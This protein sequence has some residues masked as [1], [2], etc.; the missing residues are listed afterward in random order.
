[1][2]SFHQVSI[3]F[4]GGQVVTARVTEEQL[5]ALLSALAGT[6]GGGWHELSTEDGSLRLDIAQVAYVRT[7][8][9][10]HRVGFRA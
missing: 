7:D 6:A 3:G 8:S 1:M 2:A 9:D 4:G 5:Q 10:E